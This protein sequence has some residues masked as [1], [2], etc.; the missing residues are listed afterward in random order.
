MDNPTYAFEELI[1]LIR[2]AATPDE[3]ALICRVVEDDL[4]LYC[5]FHGRLIVEALRQ[6]KLFFQWLSE[7]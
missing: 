6:R 1:E 3:I 5:Q 7:G 4:D 2:W